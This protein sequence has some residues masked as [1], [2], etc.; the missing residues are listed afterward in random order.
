[1][2]LRGLRRGADSLEGRGAPSGAEGGDGGPGARGDAPAAS[3]NAGFTT[4]P[5]YLALVA[6]GLRS[7]WNGT[8]SDS[9]SVRG[10]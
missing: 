1:M 10:V 4:V 9:V 6:P 3:S 7:G 2:E 8:A 5:G